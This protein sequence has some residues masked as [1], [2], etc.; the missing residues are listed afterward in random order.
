MQLNLGRIYFLH[1]KMFPKMSLFHSL[2]RIIIQFNNDTNSP[3]ISPFFYHRRPN[4]IMHKPSGFKSKWTIERTYCLSLRYNNDNMMFK[5]DTRQNSSKPF[6]KVEFPLYNTYD[7]IKIFENKVSSFLLRSFPC[8][9]I[10]HNGHIYSPYM[11]W[12]FFFFFLTFMNRK[13]FKIVYD[14]IINRGLKN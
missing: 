3:M 5:L 14:N 8:E 13:I 12:S 1:L 6:W 10:S 9:L 4:V 11:H 7:S 2:I